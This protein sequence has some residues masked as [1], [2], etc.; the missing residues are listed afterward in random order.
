MTWSDCLCEAGTLRQSQNILADSGKDFLASTL[1]G[2]PLPHLRDPVA[3]L[4]QAGNDAQIC[5]LRAKNSITLLLY[6]LP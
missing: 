3:C 5:H 4:L 6:L 1:S 2:S